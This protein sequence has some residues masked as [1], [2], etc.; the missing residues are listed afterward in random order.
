MVEK[1]GGCA[2]QSGNTENQQNNDC[3]IHLLYG[4]LFV[5]GV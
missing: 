2:A 4:D 1:I 5:Q 3:D